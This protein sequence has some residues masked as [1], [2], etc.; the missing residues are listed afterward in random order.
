VVFLGSFTV[1]HLRYFFSS[2]ST[3]RRVMALTE[4]QSQLSLSLSL[5]L[6]PTVSRPVCPGIKHP[7]GACCLIIT[8]LFLW[9]ALSDERTSLSFVYAA[10]TLQCS[11]SW[12][13]GPMV[14]RPYLLSQIWDFPFRSLLR[15]AGSRWRYLTPPPHGLKVNCGCYSRYVAF[16]R[17]RTE[18]PVPLLKSVYGIIV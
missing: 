8:V 5:M 1:S 14:S 18:N 7:S 10:D 4:S 13:R 15:L 2:P 16:A 12:V 17:T 9:S 6:R 3:T 11:P